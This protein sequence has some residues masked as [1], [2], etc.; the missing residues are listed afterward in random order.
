[1]FLAVALSLA[2][3]VVWNFLFP[4]KPPQRAPARQ[5]AVR[6]SPAPAPLETGAPAPAT[7][8]A[9]A[10]PGASGGG[11]A[12]PLVQAA[13]EERVTLEAPG[14]RAVFTNRGAQLVSLEHTTSSGQTLDLVRKRQQPPYPYGLVGSGLQPDPLNGALFAAEPSGDGRSVLFRYSGPLGAA[15]KRFGFDEQGLLQVEARVPGRRDWGLL[16]GPGVRN[17]TEEELESQFEMRGAVIRS[18]DEVTVLDAKGAEEGTA[19]NGEGLRWV[20]VEDTFFLAAAIP[21]EGLGSVSLQPVLVRT[22]AGGAGGA[23]FAP[24]PPKDQLTDEQEDLP[25]EYAVVLRPEGDRLSLLSYWGAKEQDRLA[26]LPY[27]LEEAIQW[28]TLGILARPL[29]AGLRWIYENVVANYGWAIILMTLL[30]K[31]LTLP[32]THSSMVSMKK[33]QALNPKM[34]AIRERYRPKLRDKQGKPNMEMQRKMNEEVMA[35]YRSEGVNPAG[36]CLPLLIQMPILFA[37]YRMLTVAAEL[38]GAP[39]LGWIQDLSIHDPYY[40]LPIVMGAT[41]FLQVKLGPQAP[42][43]MQRRLFLFMPVFMTF[44]FLGFPSGLVLYWLTNNVLTIVQQSVYNHLRKR[45][46]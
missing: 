2:V 44:F 33:M 20:G 5:E 35:L 41:Q 42:D 16:L 6:E 13:A 14:L 32:L 8:G 39:W 1:M 43:P 27:G 11:A 15:E 19:L 18:G 10:T 12:R 34:Q 24:L 4:P 17:P 9:L 40:V 46:Q 36:G 31:I 22:P 25:R 23:A 29:L 30:I 3:L 45:E 7:P 37:F 38:R 21:L 28:G 26:A